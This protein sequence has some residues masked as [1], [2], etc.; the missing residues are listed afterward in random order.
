MMWAVIGYVIGILATLLAMFFLIARLVGV[1]A[2]RLPEWL[3]E[4]LDFDE[5]PVEVASS[6]FALLAIIIAATAGRDVSHF[7]PLEYA[8]AIAAVIDLVVLGIFL[9]LIAGAAIVVFIYFLI[10]LPL[11][12]FDVIMRRSVERLFTAIFAIVAFYVVVSASLALLLL[13][14]NAFGPPLPEWLSHV[15]LIIL[16]VVVPSIVM[17]GITAAVLIGMGRLIL[18]VVTGE[19]RPQRSRAPWN[20]DNAGRRGDTLP[21]RARDLAQSAVSGA[22][23]AFGGGNRER[24]VFHGSSGRA[25]EAAEV[26][27]HFVRQQL[28]DYGRSLP[29]RE[30]LEIPPGLVESVVPRELDEASAEARLTALLYQSAQEEALLFGRMIDTIRCFA[31]VRA[32]RFPSLPSLAGTELLVRRLRWWERRPGEYP[33]IALV[34]TRYAREFVDFLEPLKEW[35]GMGVRISAPVGWRPQRTCEHSD[36]LGTVAGYITASNPNVKYALTCAHVL[37][38][39]CSQTRLTRTGKSPGTQPDAALLYQHACVGTAQRGEPARFIPRRILR[40]L[41]LKKTSVY[42]AGGYSPK[43]IGFVKNEQASYVAKDETVEDFPACIVQTKRFRYAWRAVPW[44]PIRRRFS[45]EGD[46]GSW[47]MV[48]RAQGPSLWLGMVAAGGD[49]DDK[50]ESYVIKASALKRYLRGQLKNER[51]IFPFLTEDF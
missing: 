11:L 17:I 28:L 51:P 44:P 50:M 36:E 8:T 22:T 7:G 5:L 19:R 41:W 49:G 29:T 31:R 37:P 16:A 34:R 23:S 1:F 10:A 48:R 38:K 32:E 27:R 40:R 25:R 43:V 15:A 13:A 42:R 14:M 24:P 45:D 18:G 30:V 46:S 3:Q 20:E 12:I 33:W 39:K 26:R 4:L 21:E 47:V 35:L 9:V 6:L 2:A